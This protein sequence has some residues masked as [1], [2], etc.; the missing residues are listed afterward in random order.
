MEGLKRLL[1][2][3]PSAL[4]G[5]KERVSWLTDEFVVDFV[6]HFEEARRR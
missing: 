4:K 2:E 3:A 5:M 6:N 1:E